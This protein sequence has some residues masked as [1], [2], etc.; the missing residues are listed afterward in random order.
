ML[1]K[2][3]RRISVVSKKDK[4]GLHYDGMEELTENTNR[5]ATEL[6]ITHVHARRRGGRGGTSLP[7]QPY[8]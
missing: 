3:E 8:W 4:A 1:V 7:H 2:E 6:P 5:A